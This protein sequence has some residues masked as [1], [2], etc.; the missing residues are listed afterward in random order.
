MSNIQTQKTIWFK[1]GYI[2]AII[3]VITIIYGSLTKGFT[4]GHF[5]VWISIILTIGILFKLV[6]IFVE[7]HWLPIIP[8]LLYGV[9]FGIIFF[10]GA[11]TLTDQFWGINYSGGNFSNVLK[12]LIFIGF[13]MIMSV[14]LLF[15]KQEK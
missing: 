13:S 7:Y 8:T 6:N 2:P 11:P 1:L 9:A 12:Y 5:S 4:G 3:A 15:F 14:I 10:Y